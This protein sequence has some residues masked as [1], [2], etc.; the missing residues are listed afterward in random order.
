MLIYRVILSDGTE[1]SAVELEDLKLLFQSK[2]VGSDSLVQ[3][4]NGSK[5]YALGS[6]FNLYEWDQEA[7]PYSVIRSEGSEQQSIGISKLRELYSSRDINASSLVFDSGDKKWVPLSSRFDIHSW[8]QST[9][10]QT[11]SKS[12]SQASSPEDPAQIGPNAAGAESVGQ[13]EERPDVKAALQA[14]E[15]D[16]TRRR[17]ASW[18]LLANSAFWLGSLILANT[19]GFLYPND[20]MSTG[21]QV[22][23]V[24]VAFG[25]IRGGD[26]WR[27]FACF[28]A[29]F[30]LLLGFYPGLVT[31]GASSPYQG[32]FNALWCIGF[33]VLLW[34]KK[35][36]SRRRIVGAGLVAG[37]QFAILAFSLFTV[38]IPVYRLRS[39]IQSYSIPTKTVSDGDLGYSITIPIGW[40][41]IKRDNPILNL[42]DAK[43]I[44][45]NLRSGVFAAF[46]AELPTA[47]LRSP[48]N[49]LDQ[50]EKRIK[51]QP[52]SHFRELRRTDILMN[53]GAWRK[54][55]VEWQ[56][57]GEELS[58]VFLV[59]RRG[60]LFYSLRGWSGKAFKSRAEESFLDLQ[61]AVTISPEEPNEK[62]TVGFVRGLQTKNPLISERAARQLVEAASARSYTVAEIFQLIETAV[63]KGRPGLTTAEQNELDALYMRAFATLS[64]VERRTLSSYYDK[65]NA[66]QKIDSSEAQAAEK[67]ILK[68]V[69]N[70][71]E[72]VQGQFRMV[73]SKMVESGLTRLE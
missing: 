55:E 24:I 23:N 33:L 52:S 47:G 69:R 60:W 3:Q 9:V 44:A 32:W 49:Y 54:A 48:D 46:L 34:G 51:D 18:L 11:D 5:W 66:G 20:I 71:P 10:P 21:S 40:T 8:P 25:L 42:P 73:F 68:G 31:E 67:L 17:W 64:D 72:S 7:R 65:L 1:K 57:S 13:P 2:L 43:M 14:I 22:W 19:E 53:G 12:Q 27:A 50:V 59:A 56:E 70:L 38:M 4:E 28:R 26:G 35:T 63:E 61:R 15:E 6:L 41:V 45:V 39:T 36:N 16:K 62:F 37:G 30:G 29:A 58:G